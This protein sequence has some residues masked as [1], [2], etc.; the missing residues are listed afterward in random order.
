MYNSVISFTLD[1]V[2]PWTYIAKRRLDAAL[3]Q[4]RSDPAISSKVTFAVKFLPY[5]L[6]PTFPAGP[7]EDKYAWMRDTKFQGADEKMDMFVTVMRSYGA[8]LGIDFKFTG[9][10]A[11]TLHA[12]RVLQHFQESKGAETANRIVDALYRTYF[13]QEKSPSSTETLLAAC[14]EAGIDEDEAKAVVEDESEGLADVKSAIRESAMNGID[15]VP[16]IVVEGKRRDFT[17]VGAKEIEDYVKTLTAIAKE[18]S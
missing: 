10:V 2:C 4:V 13:E 14:V 3:S 11:N 12:H 7:G 16:Y 15:S 5:Q 18:S 17:L 6:Y 1:T 9:T 8:P